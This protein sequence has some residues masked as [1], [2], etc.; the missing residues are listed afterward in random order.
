M[1]DR[2][3][4]LARQRARDLIVFADGVLDAGFEQLGR[5]ARVVAD[6]LLR[7]ADDLEAERSARVA[8]QGAR[9][10]AVALLTQRA[11]QTA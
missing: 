10:T 7:V 4:D 6:D 2:D 9:D 3:I 11:K 8:V 5:R 1:T